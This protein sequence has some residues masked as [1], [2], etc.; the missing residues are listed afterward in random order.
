M[1]SYVH[2]SMLF[3]VSVKLQMGRAQNKFPHMDNKVYWLVE[4]L[5]LLGLNTTTVKG[6]FELPKEDS[7]ENQ[8]K[9]TETAGSYQGRFSGLRWCDLHTGFHR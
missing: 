9:G 8:A 4:K 1:R 7:A 3:D 5:L 6:E 2:E